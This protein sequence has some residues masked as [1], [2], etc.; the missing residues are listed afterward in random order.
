MARK[1]SFSALESR[2]ARLR[3]KLRRRPYSGPSLARGIALLYRRNKSNGTW[4]LKV[5]DG[6]GAYWT[7]AFAQADDFEDS[8]G[9]SVLTF[10]R[11]AGRRE[12][13]CTRR[14]DGSAD[15]APITVDG[16]L[17]AY[18][19]DLIGAQ[20]QSL[21]CRLAAR[22]SHQRAA[23]E[24]GGIARGHRAEEMARQS[25]GHDGP[26]ARSTGLC[27]CLC[28]ALEQAAQHDKR[29]QNRDA[30]EIGLADLPNAQQAR[31]VILSDDTVREFVATAYGLD[32]QFGLLTDTLA[33]TGARPSQAVRLRVEDLHDHP[34]RP[35]LMMPK[36]AK[37]GDRNRAEKKA[38]RYSR[39][40][41]RAT[42]GQAES[43][44][45]GPCR[46]CAAAA[47]GD[48]S[49][50]GDNPGAGYHR[51]VKQIVTAIGA[52]P[53]AT[54]Y[55]LRHS[56]HRAHAA[57]QRAD[58]AGGVAAQHQ[59]RDDR[60]ELFEI[61]HRALRRHLAPRLLQHE[62]PAADNVVALAS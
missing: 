22:A 14:G 61:H 45:Q 7:K 44:G 53:D 27:R 57:A 40:D 12:E 41:H 28:A 35:K 42:G 4:V 8:D 60:E 13:A 23:V 26:V 24:A 31:N 33:V 38:E 62:P 43:G 36:S 52:D 34:V 58:Q 29:I 37:G 49:P 50:W 48:G 54:M 47:A 6:H 46:P 56:Q 5:S 18:R 20:C 2:S 16:A 10:Y 59:R 19:A 11:G 55:A 15:T 3:L 30:W 39:A 25:A 21:Q 1:V 32:D 9:K 17:T 51:E